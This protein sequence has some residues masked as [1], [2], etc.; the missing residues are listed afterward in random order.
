MRFHRERLREIADSSLSAL[1]HRGRLVFL[2]ACAAVLVASWWGAQR[3]ADHLLTQL[4]DRTGPDSPMPLTAEEMQEQVRVTQQLNARIRSQREA[5]RAYSHGEIDDS[6]GTFSPIEWDAPQARAAGTVG[7]DG[8]AS[9]VV[10]DV[11]AAAITSIRPDLPELALEAGITGTVIVRALVGPDG[12]VLDTAI[13][14]SIP[15]LNGAAENAVRRARFKPAT[16][17]GRAV[18][19][20]VQVPVAF[21]R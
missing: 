18:A 17:G 5:A 15:M 7:P 11:P 1:S 20:W 6:S 14:R 8:R 19:S 12:R 21:A 10:I 9:D 13:E 2:A 3:F 4:P 16:S